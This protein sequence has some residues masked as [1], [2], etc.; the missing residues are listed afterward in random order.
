MLKII[1]NHNKEDV[2][3]SFTIGQTFPDIQG[4]LLRIEV[5]GNELEKLME[6]K[7]IPLYESINGKPLKTVYLVWN[8]K[9]CGAILKT[10]REIL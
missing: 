3:Y 8:G 2:T 4:K 5:N 1:T 10:L 9:A 7:E 6:S